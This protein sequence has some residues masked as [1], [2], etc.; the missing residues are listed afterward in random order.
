MRRCI[1]IGLFVVLACCS[2]PAAEK[3]SS[4][5]GR[6]IAGFT[7]PDVRT[8]KPVS[9][10]EFKERKAIA[11]VFLGTACTISNSQLIELA[12]LHKEYGEKGVQFLGINSNNHDKWERIALHAKENEIPFPVLKDDQ[13]KIA[14][15]FGAVRTPEA[16]V[17]DQERKVCYRGRI[18][19]QFDLDVKK[20]KPGTR[21]LGDALDA[22]LAGKAVAV[23]ETSAP[24]CR[25]ARATKPKMD[26]TVTYSKD[27]CRILQ[28]HCQECHRA[29]Q[30]CADAA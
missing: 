17:L 28:K 22:V 12:R 24:G 16:F 5:L 20:L 23:P 14:D 2:L 21:D 4:P 27:V 11:V 7:L 13:G 10:S 19:D 6:T 30:S 29:G 18:N 25:I 1:G 9:I 3:S 26:A 8:R 15:L